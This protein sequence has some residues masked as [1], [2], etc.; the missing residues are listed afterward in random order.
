MGLGVNAVEKD[1]ISTSIA[2][3]LQKVP[4]KSDEYLAI[5]INVNEIV[6]V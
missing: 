3:F 4:I 2:V 1:L 6:K 5:C